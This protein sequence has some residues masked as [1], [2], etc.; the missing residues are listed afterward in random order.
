MKLVAK[1]ILDIDIVVDKCDIPAAI[2]VLEGAGHISAGEL[3]IADRWV[4]RQPADWREWDI[5]VNLYVI[6]AGCAALRNHLAVRDALRRSAELRLA[7]KQVKMQ[8]ASSASMQEYCEGKTS[9]LLSILRAESHCFT[10]DELA[11]IEEANR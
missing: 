10:V 11:E 2:R 1:P 7:Y 3:G 6:A 8:L 5:A 4:I 9:F